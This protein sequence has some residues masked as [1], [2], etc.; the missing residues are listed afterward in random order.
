[1]EVFENVMCYFL[2]FCLGMLFIIV[3]GGKND[4]DD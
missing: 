3:N 2:G 4:N 1:M